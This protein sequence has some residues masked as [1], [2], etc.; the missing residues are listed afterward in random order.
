MSVAL[1]DSN[2]HWECEQFIGS[3]NISGFNL[4]V[5][6]DSVL[7]PDP[8]IDPVPVPDPGQIKFF[9]PTCCNV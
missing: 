7:D 5:N 4:L 2:L 3:E 6:P 9:D 1:L 8:A